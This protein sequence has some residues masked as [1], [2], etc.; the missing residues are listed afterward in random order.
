ML[1]DG[2]L[3]GGGSTFMRT[4]GQS[5]L[6]KSIL[7]YID[8]RTRMVLKKFGELKLQNEIKIRGTGNIKS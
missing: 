8:A 5:F 3:K 4:P 1:I 7:P 2:L 6:F